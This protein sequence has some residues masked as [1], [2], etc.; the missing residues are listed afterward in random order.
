MRKKNLSFTEMSRYK[1]LFSLYVATAIVAAACSKGGTATED[2]HTTDFS[3]STTPV[4]DIFRP[5][6]NQVFNSGDTI[7]VDGRVTDNGLY[8]GSIRI[9]NDS[10]GAV[11]KEELYEIHGFQL[12]DFHIEYKAVV[13]A[14]ANYTV[15]VQFEDHGLNAGIKTARVKINP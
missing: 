1:I 6:D 15:T 14:V 10:T 5:S 12:Y 9:T 8:R 4:V 11:L 3:D 2:P 7:R 13:A